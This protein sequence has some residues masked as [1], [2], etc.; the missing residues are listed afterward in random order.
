MPSCCSRFPNAPPLAL[1]VGRDEASNRYERASSATVVA[2]KNVY[3]GRKENPFDL[4]PLNTEV[5]SVVRQA[6]ALTDTREVKR[7]DAL[8]ITSLVARANASLPPGACVARSSSLLS[9][10][11]LTR[12]LDHPNP[13]PASKRRSAISALNVLPKGAGRAAPTPAAS[14]CLGEGPASARCVTD[15]LS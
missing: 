11:I 15:A 5:I 4:S 3:W 8:A 1:G 13:D 7:C 14:S 12:A 6:L 9:P 2:P 10:A